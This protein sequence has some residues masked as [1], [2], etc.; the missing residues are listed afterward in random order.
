MALQ[1][2]RHATFD[3][4]ALCH[5]EN[6]VLV[7]SPKR[8]STAVSTGRLLWYST[9]EWNGYFD[10]RVVLALSDPQTIRALLSSEVAILKYIKSHSAIPVPEVYAYR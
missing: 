4:D 2:F 5:R 6:P 9:M 7:M 1:F 10:L 3:V 8:Q